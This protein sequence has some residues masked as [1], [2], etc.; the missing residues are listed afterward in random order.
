[1]VSKTVE[2]AFKR[3][4]VEY[5]GLGVRSDNTPAKRIYERIGFKKHK[6]RCWLNLNVEFMP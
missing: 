6:D 3:C 1:V 2:N 4:S 5:M